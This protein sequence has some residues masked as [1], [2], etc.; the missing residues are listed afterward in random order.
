MAIHLQVLTKIQNSKMKKYMQPTIKDEM[1]TTI[2]NI[3]DKELQCNMATKSS[4]YE[5]CYLLHARIK[6][7]LPEGVQI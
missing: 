1:Q 7:V 2:E 3:T 5:S 6:K 4:N